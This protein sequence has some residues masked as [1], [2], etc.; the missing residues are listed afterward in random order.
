M[1][2]P[3]VKSNWMIDH[4]RRLV[5]SGMARLQSNWKIFRDLK[6]ALFRQFDKY[7]LN[8]VGIVH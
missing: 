4:V 8:F 5:I 1:N 6:T 7:R 3:W 2:R